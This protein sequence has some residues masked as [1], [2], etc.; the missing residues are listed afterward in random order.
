M[1][2]ILFST[3]MTI[4]M[5]DLSDENELK[6]APTYELSTVPHKDISYKGRIEPANLCYVEDV[7]LFINWSDPC[8]K[9]KDR[10]KDFGVTEAV[11]RGLMKKISL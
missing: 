8:K 1:D 7:L 9:D 10:L 6:K 11:N 4:M 5:M 3:R 2:H